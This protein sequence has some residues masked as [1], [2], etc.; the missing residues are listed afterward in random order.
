MVPSVATSMTICLLIILCISST[1]AQIIPRKCATDESIWRGHCCPIGNDGSPCSIT[2][3]R[4]KCTKINPPKIY[5]PNIIKRYPKMVLDPRFMWPSKSFKK[6]REKQITIFVTTK[7]EI[8]FIPDVHNL[9][10][11]LLVIYSER[12]FN[13]PFQAICTNCICLAQCV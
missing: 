11:I 8:E 2:S 4:G 1:F 3:G 6:V 9:G 10:K 13:G 7:L 5:Q 12:A